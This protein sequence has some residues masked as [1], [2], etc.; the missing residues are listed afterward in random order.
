MKPTSAD[1]ARALEGLG[2]V[3][4]RLH[5]PPWRYFLLTEPEPDKWRMRSE[6]RKEAVRIGERIQLWVLGADELDAVEV[7][8]LK[9]QWGARMIPNQTPERDDEMWEQVT[10]AKAALPT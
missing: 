9:L 2:Q 4:W 1:V 5:Q 3:E 8:D 6:D 10:S 7:D